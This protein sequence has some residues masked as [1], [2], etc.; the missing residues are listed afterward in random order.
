MVHGLRGRSGTLGQ[1]VIQRWLERWNSDMLHISITPTISS[2]SLEHADIWGAVQWG[3]SLPR[4][5]WQQCPEDRRH[6]ESHTPGKTCNREEG[7]VAVTFTSHTPTLHTFTLT[8][9]PLHSRW[10]QKWLTCTK[11]KWHTW[12]HLC[13]PPSIEK[14]MSS[15][16]PACK[17]RCFNL[18]VCRDIQSSILGE[19]TVV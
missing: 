16:P 14:E 11:D 8:P 15:S 18:Q 9:H 7:Q 2:P 1:N 12:C 19:C 10:G 5:T 3:P 4:R 13:Q 17:E 6:R